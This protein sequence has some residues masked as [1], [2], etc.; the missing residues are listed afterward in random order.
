MVNSRTKGHS[1]ERHIVKQL[2]EIFPD[3]E[4]SQEGD[5]LDRAGVDLRG[6]GNLNIQAKRGRNYAPITKIEEVKVT[7]GIPVLWTKGDRKREVVAMY[8]DDFVKILKDI[9]EVFGGN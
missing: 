5:S 1:Y 6:T 9:G 7:D 8:A 3:C 4:R 2:R